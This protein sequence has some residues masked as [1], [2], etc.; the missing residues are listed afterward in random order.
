M[1]WR[2]LCQPSGAYLVFA[3]STGL[4]VDLLLKDQHWN[5]L[6]PSLKGATTGFI[7]G[8]PKK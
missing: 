5:G 7:E 8:E 3:D 2:A 4:Q 6:T 1:K